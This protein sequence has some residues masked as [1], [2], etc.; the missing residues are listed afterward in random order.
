MKE[1]SESAIRALVRLC[2]PVD[3]PLPLLGDLFAVMPTRP[4]QAAEKPAAFPPP[5]AGC[6]Q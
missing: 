3:K 5:P 6:P 4:A 1:Y 2:P